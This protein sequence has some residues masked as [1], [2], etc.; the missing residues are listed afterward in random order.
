MTSVTHSFP[1]PG[2]AFTAS[3]LRASVARR[4]GWPGD[5][6]S[7]WSPE[8][9]D[10]PLL[11]SAPDVW[12]AWTWGIAARFGWALT[13]PVVGEAVDAA[14][15][16]ASV[17]P[18]IERLRGAA[19]FD[20]GALN[21]DHLRAD[22]VVGLFLSTL[23]RVP[24]VDDLRHHVGLL[25]NGMPV[26]A[27]LRELVGCD[28]SRRARRHPRPWQE[29][30]V[31]ERPGSASTDRSRRGRSVRGTG[32]GDEGAVLAAITARLDALADQ[33][34]ATHRL[35][36]ESKQFSEE[37][38][39][40]EAGHTPST[41]RASDQR[42]TMLSDVIAAIDTL[43]LFGVILRLPWDI[44]V[45]V[46]EPGHASSAHVEGHVLPP[47]AHRLGQL[48][49]ALARHGWTITESA[50]AESDRPEA[51]SR[52]GLSRTYPG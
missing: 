6:H 12:L 16:H 14:R 41:D 31:P 52:L 27:M 46:S 4:L 38:V 18:A 35:V 20:V 21:E 5:D 47:G 40:V 7:L 26:D 45:R 1:E 36:V 10:A 3:G 32:P 19:Q 9:V 28:E 50:V 51:H 25:L 44:N 11:D 37:S 42:T 23:G 33:S 15:V 24:S 22:F 17:N 39:A 2:P 48:A 43:A 29:F 34:W 49:T 8:A 30:A 13:E